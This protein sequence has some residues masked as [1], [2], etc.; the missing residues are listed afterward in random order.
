MISRIKHIEIISDNE[1]I[2]ETLIRSKSLIHY[3]CTTSFEYMYLN[4]RKSLMP[5][6]FKKYLT[7]NKSISC[8]SVLCNSFTQLENNLKKY[9]KKDKVK[10]IKIKKSIDNIFWRIDGKSCQRI[11]SIIKKMSRR[12]NRVN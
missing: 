9:N 3:N 12:K 4:N 2:F 7:Y 8:S 1:A 5:N 6:Y 11:S 10:R